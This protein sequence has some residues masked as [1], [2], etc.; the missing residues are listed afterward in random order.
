MSGFAFLITTFLHLCLAQ[1]HANFC[2]NAS[3][4]HTFTL[5]HFS[6]DHATIHSNPRG[7]ICKISSWYIK[8]F[9]SN[10]KIIRLICQNRLSGMRVIETRNNTEEIKKI[11]SIMSFRT[12]LI[13]CAICLHMNT[14]VV[15]TSVRTLQEFYSTNFTSVLSYIVYLEKSANS[16]HKLNR[17]YSNS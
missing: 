11:K 14:H 2:C 10:F 15:H 9:A 1:A 3:E 17:F 12:Q 5:H 7:L 16:V 13:I 8:L 6:C 4:C